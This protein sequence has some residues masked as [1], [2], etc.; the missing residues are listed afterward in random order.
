MTS[1][2]P[3]RYRVLMERE[4]EAAITQRRVITFTYD[5]LERTVQPATLGVSS[6]GNLLIRGCQVDG[7]SKRNSVPC[8]ELYSLAKIRDL[9]VADEVFGDFALP[10]YTRGDSAFVRI[11]AEH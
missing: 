7:R 1:H 4:L 11:D 9:A 5:G 10:G 3:D 2:A 8:W 6:A